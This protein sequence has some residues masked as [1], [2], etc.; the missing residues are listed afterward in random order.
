LKEM[1]LAWQLEQLELRTRRSLPAE[2]RARLREPKKSPR[3]EAE[4]IRLKAKNTRW[5]HS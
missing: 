3:L 1:M 4:I 2:E 5:K